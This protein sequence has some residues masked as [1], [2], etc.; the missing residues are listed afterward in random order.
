MS[1]VSLGN[2]RGPPLSERVP[3]KG[4]RYI[5]LSEK[6]Q[7]RYP[8]RKGREPSDTCGMRNVDGELCRSGRQDCCD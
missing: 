5:V 8:S 4:R 6:K 3:S 7:M 1:R 2:G